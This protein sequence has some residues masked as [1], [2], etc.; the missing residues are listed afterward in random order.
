MEIC[1][2]DISR[3]SLKDAKN[4]GINTILYDLNKEFP[5]KANS[6]DVIVSDQ[7]IEHLTNAEAFIKEV[8]RVLKPGGYAVV[9]TENLSSWNNLFALL[10]GYGPPPMHYSDEKNI[11]G[12]P[13]LFPHYGKNP[14][15]GYPPPVKIFTYHVLKELFKIQGFLIEKLT[16]GGYY[17]APK[18]LMRIMSKIDPKH[19]PYI[20]IKIRK[21]DKKIEEMKK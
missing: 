1:G 13:L 2:F 5:L 6:F 9:S 3:K 18:F 19:S 8:Y 17:P 4:K 14:S 21:P 12:I 20:T 10:F 16:G 15:Y 7:V 11:S